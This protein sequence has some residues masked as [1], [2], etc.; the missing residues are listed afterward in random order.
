M[1]I[2]LVKGQRV[3]LDKENPGLTK[4]GVG[5]RWDANKTSSG[6]AYDID[7]SAFLLGSNGKA[8]S[9]G[10][11][12]F[13]NNL[14]S[15]DGAVVHT[16]DVTDGAAEGDD[17]TLKIDLTRVNSD[18]QEIVFIVTIHEADTRKQNFGQITG[19]GIRIYN[20]LTGAE[21]LNYDLGEDFSIETALTFGRLYRKDGEWRFE[22]TGTGYQGGLQSFVSQ[23]F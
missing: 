5:L 8:S 16:G 22:A 21:I 13:Y 23:Y 4:I 18:V 17:E 19:S 2:N 20:D 3:N 11:F 15:S 6:A 1:A 10:N 7:A 9:D 12:V 14:T